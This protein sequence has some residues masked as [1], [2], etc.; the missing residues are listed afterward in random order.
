MMGFE[1]F[2]SPEGEVL[3]VQPAPRGVDFSG[4]FGFQSPEGE[5]LTVQHLGSKQP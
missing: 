1:K 4:F 2:Q 3:T 5:V